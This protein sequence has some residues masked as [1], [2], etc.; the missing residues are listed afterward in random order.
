M[1]TRFQEINNVTEYGKSCQYLVARYTD[2][3][4]QFWYWGGFN[5]LDKAVNCAKEIDGIVR[6]NLL[7]K[8]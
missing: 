8:G 6:K 2:K 1:I 5:D 7:Y 4:D 3:D